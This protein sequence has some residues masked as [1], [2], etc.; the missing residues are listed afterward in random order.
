MLD[1]LKIPNKCL[2]N[3]LK[4]EPIKS[5]SAERITIYKSS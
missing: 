5:K 4:D 1:M 3:K 2:L